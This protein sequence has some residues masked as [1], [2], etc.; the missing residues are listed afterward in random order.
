MSNIVE[1]LIEVLRVQEI[2]KNVYLGKAQ[3]LGMKHLFGGHVLAQA[4]VAAARTVEEDRFCHSLHGYF[5]RAGK[6]ADPIYYEVDLLRS[7]KSFST[8]HVVAKQGGLAIFSMS[9]SFQGLE[10]GFDHQSTKPSVPGPDGIL[11]ELEQARQAKDKIPKE[12]R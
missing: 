9:A 5:L 1:S 6:T 2:E 11:S 8:R 10:G 12:N 7:G 3:D 4:L